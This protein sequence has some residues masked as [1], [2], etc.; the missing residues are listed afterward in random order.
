M[1]ETADEKA[2]DEAARLNRQGSGLDELCDIICNKDDPEYDF[3][4]C[5]QCKL[6]PGIDEVR[7]AQ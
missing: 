6:P 7:H 5:V 3:D 2:V 1:I 4:R